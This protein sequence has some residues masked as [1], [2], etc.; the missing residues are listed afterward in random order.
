[1]K[2]T[3]MLWSH[4]ATANSCPILKDESKL[5]RPRPQ[6]HSNSKT[7]V[8]RNKD[9]AALALVSYGP[10]RATHFMSVEKLEAAHMVGVYTKRRVSMRETG[11]IST[12]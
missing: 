6:L 10:P 5:R 3:D 4:N 2:V 9:A 11:I 7:P 1:M 12:I 8:R